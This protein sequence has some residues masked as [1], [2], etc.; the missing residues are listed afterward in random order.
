MEVEEED[1]PTEEETV[2]RAALGQNLRANHV[3]F[4]CQCRPVSKQQP[5]HP[6]EQL[7]QRGTPST[8]KPTALCVS[9]GTAETAR[10]ISR[11]SE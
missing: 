10:G 2:P 3:R 11:R 8:L 4:I 7:R 9:T 6:H 1:L 5:A